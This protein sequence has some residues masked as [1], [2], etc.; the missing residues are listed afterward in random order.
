MFYQTIVS[1]AATF[2]YALSCLGLGMW[3]WSMFFRAQNRGSKEG[4]LAEL[5]T[6]FLL[7]VSL[8]T[9]FLTF[10]GLAGGLRTGIIA[11]LM[12][13]GVLGLWIYRGYLVQ[14]LDKAKYT[15]ASWRNESMWLKLIALGGCTVGIGFAFAAWVRPPL[16][17]AEAFYLV[18]PKIMAATGTLQA[19][20]GLYHSFS[21]IG[22]T[23]ELHYTALM[24]L[25]DTAAAKLFVWPVALASGVLLAAITKLCGGGR[26]A[27][28]IAWIVLISSST[29]NHY[30]YDGKVDLFAAAFGL[31][32]IYWLILRQTSMSVWS[33]YALAGYF[34]G[35]A[36][37]AKFSYIPTLGVT[38]VVLILWRE[39][40]STQTL[41][42][43]ISGRRPQQL[44]LKISLLGAMAA[45]A[46]IPQ[47]LKNGFLFNAPLA[48][49]FGYVQVEDWLNQAWFSADVTRHILLTYP[50]ALIFGRYP[51]QGGGL[52]FLLLALAP[53][54]VVLYRPKKWR[55]SLL[56]GVTLSGIAAVV[57]WMIIRPSVIAP[58]Y[59]LSSLL[60]FVPLVAVATETAL[61]QARDSGLL[62]AGVFSISIFA[63]ATAS[64]HLLPVPGAL[65]ATLQ[66]K[67]D[68]CLLAS[69]Y[70]EPMRMLARN[71]STGKRVFVA[72][73]Y[74]YWLRADQLQ[75]RD[76][77]DEHRAAINQ[78]DLLLWLRKHG[79]IYVV[80]DSNSHPM[81][82]EH[83][84]RAEQKG[85]PISVVLSSS[86]LTIYQLSPVAKPLLG[87]YQTE[88]GRWLVEQI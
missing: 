53:L 15:L 81:I 25:A 42:A 27:R 62:R 19:M 72:A 9:A 10:V 77:E 56:T 86:A 66:G 85:G 28:T 60:M 20:T 52:S 22:L 64:W 88:P 3:L 40:L 44:V 63:L 34:S 51:M 39:F 70:C 87:C 82:S 61:H 73:Y 31:A 45:F 47:L 48:P 84:K 4:C 24:V 5:A 41:H 49:F 80:V 33:N 13:P 16:G 68:G 1:L 17:D 76:N 21:T 65:I 32:A 23:A 36:A 18:Y 79:F 74:T 46:W 12:A 30:V 38:I 26:V 2:I 50:F 29:F 78:N 71:A 55:S 14:A 43:E 11:M 58:R 75:C 35:W 67:N 8:Y 69:A 59:L 6:Q 83:L 54:A 7:G 37:V 57:V